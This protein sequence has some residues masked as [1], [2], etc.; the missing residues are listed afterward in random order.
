MD[1]THLY[2]E[3][4]KTPELFFPTLFNQPAISMNHNPREKEVSSLEKLNP[5]RFWTQEY[6]PQK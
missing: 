6:K 1:L 4:F 2:K 5:K 3:Q